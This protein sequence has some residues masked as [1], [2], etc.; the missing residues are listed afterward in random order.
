MVDDSELTIR[1]FAES[2]SPE[3]SALWIEVFAY[4]AAHNVP[5]ESIRRK[6]AR[7]PELFFVA[8]VDD[9]IVGTVMGGYD[10]HRG[11]IYSLAV[12]P[13]HRSRGIGTALVRRLESELKAMD[14]PKV[15]L[16]IRDTNAAVAAFYERLGYV[17]EPRISMG[18]VL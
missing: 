17:V 10:G 13:D 5:A 15:N 7:Q 11:W 16:Q 1:P 14:C 8:V 18:K 9:T 2:D 6:L 12:A 3:V 4:P